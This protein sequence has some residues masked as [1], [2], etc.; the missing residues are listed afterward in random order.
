MYKESAKY[1]EK[2]SFQVREDPV[3]GEKTRFLCI[4]S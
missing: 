2:P 4:I 1:E 3:T